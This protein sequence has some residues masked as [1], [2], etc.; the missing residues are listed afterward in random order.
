MTLV[1]PEPLLGVDLL[2]GLAALLDLPASGFA[3]APAGA[4]PVDVSETPQHL[5]VRAALPGVSADDVRLSVE[6]G[7]LEIRARTREAAPAEQRAY[8]VREIPEG[9][10]ARTIRL[11]VAVDAS[12]AEA[13]L[14]DGILTVTLPKEQAAQAKQIKIVP[15][16]QAAA[17][18]SSAS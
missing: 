13:V 15:K 5:R 17:V 6:N 7:A 14:E 3:A 11:P 18:G 1:R 10:L 4:F 16:E 9:P 12:K 8:L 2:S